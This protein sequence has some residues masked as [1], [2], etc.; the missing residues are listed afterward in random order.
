[1][2]EIE[3]EVEAMISEVYRFKEMCM[4]ITRRRGGL[5]HRLWGS[6]S[7]TSQTV[8]IIQMIPYN[9]ECAVSD[10]E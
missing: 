1:M 2:L 4:M 7:L 10:T 8:G 5:V 3:R 6:S 9:Y